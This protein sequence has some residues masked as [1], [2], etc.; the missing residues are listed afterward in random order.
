[1]AK[2]RGAVV[3]GVNKTGGLPLLEASADGAD[4]VEKWLIDEG[5]EVKKIT[6][7]AGPVKQSD[8]ARAIDHFVKSGTYQQLVIYFSGHGYWK[9]DAELWLLTD[10]PG[11]ANAAVSWAETA[12]FAKDCGIPN[13]VMISDACRVIPTT[14][15]DLRVR[16]SIVFPNDDVQRSRAKVDKF[17]AAAQGTAAYEV[18]IGTAAKKENVFTHC[19]LRAF[20]EPD[21][22]M[23]Q[24]V[25]ENGQSIK[26]VPNRRL[27]KYLQREVAKLLANVNV[28]LNQTPDAEVLSDDDV[29]IGRAQAPAIILGTSVS[30]GRDLRVDVP[31]GRRTFLGPN[32]EEPK[33]PSAP[34]VHLRDVAAAAVERAL[35]QP[36][37]ATPEEISAIEELARTSGFDEAVAQAGTTVENVNHFETGTGLA[38]AGAKLAEAISADGE[39]LTVLSRGADD[40]GAVPIDPGLPSA[41]TVLLRFINGR[42]IALAALNGYIGHVVVEGERVMNVNY[43]PSNNSW[44]WYYYEQRRQ[45]I[46]RLRAA[47]AAAVQFGVFRLDDKQKAAD[48]AD[49]IRVAKEFDP[50]LGL[51]AA[52]AYS[53]ADQREEIDSV[54]DYMLQDLGCSLFDVAMLAR[55]IPGRGRQAGPIVPFCPMLTQGWN[56]LRARGVALPPVLD[57][58]QDELEPALWTTFKPERTEAIFRAIQRGEFK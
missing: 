51:Y 22:D 11:D 3:I 9:N 53:D 39:R 30:A 1:V 36:V 13:V 7:A 45:Q 12:E 48:L 50:T 25:A 58:A 56:L 42:G 32:I 31:A 52:Y 54:L 41:C 16:G 23:I 21:S 28:A 6:D 26:V 47:A 18:K 20:Q 17:M 38:V 14:P 37:Q 2:K 5:F 19:F 24:V 15:R 43:V 57:G 40:P 46:E 55:K 29:Y 35:D 34:V 10:A 27:G 4:A 44:R 8:I 49:R 33:P